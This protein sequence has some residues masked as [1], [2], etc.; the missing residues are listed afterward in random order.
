MTPIVYESLITCLR[1]YFC[2]FEDL[3]QTPST[4]QG[5]YGA[6]LLNLIYRHFQKVVF[7]KIF[8]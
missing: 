3:T 1:E 2:Y 4:T 7:I 5:P 6:Q 8:K